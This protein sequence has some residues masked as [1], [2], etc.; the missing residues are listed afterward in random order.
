ME[1]YDNYSNTIL[2]EPGTLR[3]KKVAYMCLGSEIEI[4]GLALLTIHVFG[5]FLAMFKSEDKRWSI[6]ANDLH[7]LYHDVI[8]F[9][10]EFYAVDRNGRIVLVGL[11][12]NVSLVTEKV[13]GGG[14]KKYLVESDGQLLLVDMYLSLVPDVDDDEV[15]YGAIC[16]YRLCFKVYNLDWDGKR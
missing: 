16:N 6:I 14:D 9:R 10:D 11:S 2:N 8:L 5:K 15:F 3:T 13:F 7:S 12:S 4:E 1:F